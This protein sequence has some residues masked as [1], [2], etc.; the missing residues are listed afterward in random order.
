M[1]MYWSV[2]E[3]AE[4]VNRHFCFKELDVDQECFMILWL[5]ILHTIWL[6]ILQFNTLSITNIY[7]FRTVLGFTSYQP[8]VL[9]NKPSQVTI[10][11]GVVSLLLHTVEI[12]IT[13]FKYIQ[14]SKYCYPGKLLGTTVAYWIKLLVLYHYFHE[15]QT[16]WR[17][18][19]QVSYNLLTYES[20]GHGYVSENI[21]MWGRYLEVNQ[22]QLCY[23][24][25]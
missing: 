4:L 7:Q 15:Y 2:V 1:T 20:P 22:P 16:S 10:Y 21:N 6:Y 12:R 17:G 3:T 14:H 24:G 9:E 13:I 18:K 25:G 8:F 11:T 5:V 23:T 19:W